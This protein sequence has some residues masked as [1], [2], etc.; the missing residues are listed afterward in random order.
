MR[1]LSILQPWAWVI[2]HGH[3]TVENRVW[4]TDVRGQFLI[5]A[6]KRW[7]QE[8]ENDLNFI[9]NQFP[10][11]VLPT[12]FELGGIVG[13]AT[14]TGCVTDLDDPW[15][16]GPYGFLLKDASPLPFTPYRG[17][18]R[19]FDVSDDFLISAGLL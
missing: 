1:A 6:G 18:Q 9:R 8:Q 4:K 3:K 10:R 16:F 15:F 11:I 7:G 13:R 5:H 19:W 17:S 2:S 14:I 12:S